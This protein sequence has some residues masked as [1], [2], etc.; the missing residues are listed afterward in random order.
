[1]L[2]QKQQK[3]MLW[4]IIAIIEKFSERN[5]Q[6]SHLCHHLYIFCRKTSAKLLTRSRLPTFI[7][8]Y[9][10]LSQTS[11]R[12]LFLGYMWELPKTQVV[13]R[14]KAADIAN[15]ISNGKWNN[16]HFI[17]ELSIWVRPWKSMIRFLKLRQFID[18]RRGVIKLILTRI[19][20][21]KIWS[22][23]PP[24]VWKRVMGMQ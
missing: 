8:T 5:R 18:W 23:F 7:K 10:T 12:C 19:K 16:H 4:I 20:S 9:G 14:G 21:R 17:E 22:F 11:K 1:M 13:T 2:P 15:S 6:R 24:D 3:K